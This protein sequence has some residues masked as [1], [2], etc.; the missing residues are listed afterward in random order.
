MKSWLHLLLAV[1]QRQWQGQAK[2]PPYEGMKIN[3]SKEPG[4]SP[5][6]L[7]PEEADQT[8]LPTF[9]TTQ[10]EQANKHDKK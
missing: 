4:D 8:K 1:F 2:W 6:H 7:I 3:E 5:A 10:V 9:L